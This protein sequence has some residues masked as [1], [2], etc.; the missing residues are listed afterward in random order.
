MIYQNSKNVYIPANINGGGE[1][2]VL[3][4][5]SCGCNVE[6]EN[7]NPKLK[8]LVYSKIPSHI[9]YADNLLKGLSC[10]N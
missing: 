4:A 3:E 10:L 6:V 1:R 8:E 2:A 5:R 7:D 9:D